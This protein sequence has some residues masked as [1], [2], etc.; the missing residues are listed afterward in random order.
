MCAVAGC[1]SQQKKPDVALPDLAPAAVKETP[2]PQE[3]PTVKEQ[4][5]L[6]ESKPAEVKPPEPTG[7]VC[8]HS[9]AGLE[10]LAPIPGIPN[11]PTLVNQ[12]VA[13]FATSDGNN[14]KLQNKDGSMSIVTP[15]GQQHIVTSFCKEP[16]GRLLA[17]AAG[18]FGMVVDINITPKANRAFNIKF[19]HIDVD[20]TVQ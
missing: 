8:A 18:P 6:A 9:W 3:T 20:A 10:S 4:P 1:S 15:D 17:K 13:T 2:K 14:Y 16:D 5:E 19:M 11:L 12:G 7:P